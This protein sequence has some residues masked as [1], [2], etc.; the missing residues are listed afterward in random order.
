MRVSFSPLPN[1]SRLLHN[2]NNC[3]KKLL[4][5]GSQDV[6]SQIIAYPLS[7]VGLVAQ[8]LLQ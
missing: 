4:T 7:L 2:S 5:T 3:R 1:L 6:G 8:A